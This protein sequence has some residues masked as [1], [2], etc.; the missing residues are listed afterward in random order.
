ME[1]LE[2]ANQAAITEA[3]DSL[4]LEQDGIKVCDISLAQ[5]S[6]TENPV[7][8]QV[9]RVEITNLV[10]KIENERWGDTDWPEK[11]GLNGIKML[12]P[13]SIDNRSLKA[14]IR[15]RKTITRTDRVK[16]TPSDNT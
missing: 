2:S 16:Q 13:L 11:P 7:N 9:E 12:P 10:D 6:C 3:K 5:A 4:N 15:Q 1:K 14:T 8:K